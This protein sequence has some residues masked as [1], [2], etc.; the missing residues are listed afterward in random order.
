MPT[1]LWRG[2]Y[3]AEGSK[4]LVKDGGSKR[5]DVVQQMI[6]KAGGKLL[7]FYFAVGESDVYGISEF[8]DLATAVSLSLAINASGAVNFHTTLL[9]TPEEM[10]AA[11]KKTIAYT[12]PGS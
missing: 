7:A 4:G 9:L 2:S 3:T 11:T 1:F 8:P 12:A 10:D 5:R 6:T